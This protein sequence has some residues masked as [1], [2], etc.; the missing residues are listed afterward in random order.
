MLVKEFIRVA[1]S[2][3]RIMFHRY[4]DCIYL[5]KNV[6]LK[7]RECEIH[8]IKLDDFYHCYDITLEDN[9]DD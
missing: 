5:C 4:E 8:S 3:D 9:E 7:F 1:N 2:K 6:P